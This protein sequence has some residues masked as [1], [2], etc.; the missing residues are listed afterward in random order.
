V[1]HL[2]FGGGSKEVSKTAAAGGRASVLIMMDVV[3]EDGATIGEKNSDLS[4]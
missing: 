2:A 3:E 4:Q 1:L